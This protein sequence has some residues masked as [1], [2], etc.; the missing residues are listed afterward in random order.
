[1]Q[2][3][4]FIEDKYLCAHCSVL[5]ALSV[6]YSKNVDRV[7]RHSSNRWRRFVVLLF[8][9]W[10]VALFW[11]VWAVPVLFLQIAWNAVQLVVVSDGRW[12]WWLLV[13]CMPNSECHSFS[14]TKHWFCDKNGSRTT[15]NRQASERPTEQKKPHGRWFVL[16]NAA[17]VNTNYP[18][19]RSKTF[20][21]KWRRE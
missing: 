17:I 8:F 13:S 6:L 5:T 12:W 7:A 16:Q 21:S 9:A 11:C 2:I 15:R 1:M 14:L 18:R 4:V 10:F 3:S 19:D 20:P